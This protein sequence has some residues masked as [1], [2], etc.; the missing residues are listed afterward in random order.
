MKAPNSDAGDQFGYSLAMQ[1][2]TLVVGAQSESGPGTGMDGNPNANDAT[3]AGAITGS[4]GVVK[5]GPATQYL[6]GTVAPLV[7]VNEGMLAGSG[8]LLGG[9]VVDGTGTVSPGAGAGHWE[10][11][12]SYLQAGTMLA[13]LG[14]PMQGTQYDWTEVL[15]V[16]FWIPGATIDV[17]FVNGWV[18]P[19]EGIEYYILTA[20]NGIFASV[21][22]LTFD[23]SGAP[24]P[25][26]QWTAK[27]VPWGA[28]GQALVL[29]AVPEPATMALLGLAGAALAGYARRRRRDEHSTK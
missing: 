28:T 19:G 7:Q 10:V 27:I 13:E 14:G 15:G 12:N 26:G 18:P 29:V 9:L 25:A 2:S 16:A 20:T 1:R 3:Y 6:G 22:D 11:T 17:D 4:A 21:D 23:F 8:Q 5:Y 24:L